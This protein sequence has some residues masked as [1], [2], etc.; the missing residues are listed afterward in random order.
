MKLI[1]VNDSFILES[2]VFQVLRHHFGHEPFYTT[3]FD[4]FR[5]VMMRRRRSRWIDHTT[6]ICTGE[7]GRGGA[8]IMAA[9]C[10]CMF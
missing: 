3:L 5:E 7:A 9:T 6:K 4:L 1:A 8:A 2:N 10:V